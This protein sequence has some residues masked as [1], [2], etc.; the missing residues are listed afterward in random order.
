MADDDLS[1]FR[2][3]AILLQDEADGE[4]KDREE[5]MKLG[6]AREAKQG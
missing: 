6:M 4:V 5:M 1:V 3:N 2:R